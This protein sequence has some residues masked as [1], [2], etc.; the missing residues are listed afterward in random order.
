MQYHSLQDWTLVLPTDTSTTECHFHFGPAVSFFLELLA[1][2]F[3]SSPV[4][5]WIPSNSDGS[6][7][8]VIYFCLFILFT[9]L[10]QQEYRNCLSFPPPVDHV[11]S[12]LSTI[13]L[14]WPYMA[15]LIASLSYTTLHQDKAVIHEG[16]KDMRIQLFKLGQAVALLLLFSLPE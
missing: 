9:G 13:C 3:H 15:W 14:G 5:Y 8:S 2:A 1:V 11:L 12:E 4:A 7:S 10:S 6:S 16:G